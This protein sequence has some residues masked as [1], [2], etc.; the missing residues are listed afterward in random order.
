LTRSQYLLRPQLLS[1]S[2]RF[3]CARLC[4]GVIPWAYENIVPTVLEEP[5]I[6]LFDIVRWNTLPSAAAVDR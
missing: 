2:G 1:A 5:M 3:A 4:N 6:G